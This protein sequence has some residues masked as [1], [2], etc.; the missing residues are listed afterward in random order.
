MTFS[1]PIMQQ[2]TGVNAY[3]SQ[4]AFIAGK[5][6][7]DDFIHYVSMIMCIVQFFSAIFAVYFLYKIDRR[8]MILIGNGI[9]GIC[10]IIMGVLFLY[11]ED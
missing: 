4:M 9:M 7:T 2:F 10:N 5:L 3:I 6:S 11:A 1:L 8:K